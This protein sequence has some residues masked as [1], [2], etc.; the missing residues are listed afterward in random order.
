MGIHHYRRYLAG[1]YLFPKM[2]LSEDRIERVLRK[3]DIILPRRT[4]YIAGSAKADYTSHHIASDLE[5]C[6]SV[7]LDKQP[8]YLSSF[9]LFMQ[10]SSGFSLNMMIARRVVFDNYLSW[11]FP[12][13]FE[14]ENRLTQ[15][16]LAKR[17]SY[18]RRALGFLSERLLNV[19]LTHNSS[20]KIWQASVYVTEAQKDFHYYWKAIPVVLNARFLKRKR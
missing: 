19:W 14:I 13:L 18:N 10:A 4:F 11:L 8:E 16:E 6:R 2:P 20:I 12:I 3:Y 9:D 17:D 15:D 7:I 1:G 5:V